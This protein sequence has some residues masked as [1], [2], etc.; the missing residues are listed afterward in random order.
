MENAREV[1]SSADSGTTTTLDDSA[2]SGADDYWKTAWIEFTSGTNDGQFR[3]VTSYGG[4]NSRLAW[5]TALPA[6]V[7]NGDTY[8]VTFYYISG[9]TNSSLNYVY[10]ETFSRTPYER[11]IIFTANTTGVAPAGAIYLAT[12][13]LDGSGAAT[14]SDSDP[15]GSD[16]VLY[17][18]IGGHHTETLT[19]TVLAVPGAGSVEV[20]RSH[21]SLLYRGGMTLTVAAGFT[22]T[23]DQYWKADEV[24]FTVTNSGSYAADCA[25]TLTVNGRQ[26]TYPA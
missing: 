17:T 20:T 12:I 8:T 23:V 15:A 6:T 14:A 24:V 7:A 2:L 16:R 3:Q 11:V 25:Y 9:L 26:Q 21:T 18:D 1:S 13:T 5:D 22:Y 10:G 19:G 4:T